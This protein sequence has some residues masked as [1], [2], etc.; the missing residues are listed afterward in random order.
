MINY[1]PSPKNYKEKF[2]LSLESQQF[3]FEYQY[4]SIEDSWYLG[5][6]KNNVYVLEF[7]KLV[8]GIVF[9]EYYQDFPL[10]NGTLEIYSPVNDDSDPNLEN[11]GNGVYLIYRDK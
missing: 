3:Q 4:N 8:S 10:Q 5:L 6:S 2:S 7:V 11:F 9:G 1:L